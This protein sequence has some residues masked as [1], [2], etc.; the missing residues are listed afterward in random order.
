LDNSSKHV[1]GSCATV[2]TRLLA[3]SAWPTLGTNYNAPAQEANS[4]LAELGTSAMGAADIP[5]HAVGSK[6]LSNI[7]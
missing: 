6:S 2:T 5:A 1:D 4:L 7:V 3:L